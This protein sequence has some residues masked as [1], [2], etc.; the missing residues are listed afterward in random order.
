MI[1]VFTSGNIVLKNMETNAALRLHLI[2]ENISSFYGKNFSLASICFK[3]ISAYGDFFSCLFLENFS[4]FFNYFFL[5]ILI[6]LTPT[7]PITAELLSPL[8]S[9]D[10]LH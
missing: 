9:S 5:K 4:D 10:P 7:L 8:R 3:G 2:V 6:S 1:F